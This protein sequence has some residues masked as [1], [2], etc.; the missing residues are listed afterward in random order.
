MRQLGLAIE[1]KNFEKKREM[2]KFV[3]DVNKGIRKDGADLAAKGI[4]L[5]T[6]QGLS[7]A[8]AKPSAP[9]SPPPAAPAAPSPEPPK[10]T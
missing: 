5:S 9:P 1:D 8:L 3:L 6:P 4:T 7:E 10:P 2:L